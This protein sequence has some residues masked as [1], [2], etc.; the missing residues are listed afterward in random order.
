MPGVTDIPGIEVHGKGSAD[1]I[2]PVGYVD[3]S[4]KVHD[5]LVL[6]E[7]TGAEDDMMGNDDLPIGERVSNVLCACIEK[8]GDVDDKDIIKR[9]V[10]DDLEVGLPITEQDRIAAMI[11]LRRL[12]IGDLY[13]FERRCPRC[14]QMAEN[15]ATDLRT[16]KI[17]KCEHPERRRVKLVLPRSKK[18]CVIKVLTA[19]GSISVARLR[20]T[21]K[22]LKSLALIARVE[23]LDGQ[24]MGHPQ[25]ALQIIKDLPQK[26]RNYIRQVY[27]AMEAFV[28]TEIEVE[29]RNPICNAT[30]KFALDVGQGFF[31]DLEEKVSAEGLNWL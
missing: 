20:P 27:N 13:K 7:M 22:D 4:G 15:R 16:L 1:Y 31:L 10:T 25:R 24:P 23:S 21:Q 6:R 2:L 3:G 26:D 11:F 14:S 28:D 12:T 19:K 18:E 5:H 30:W 29:C 9:A 17:E 8:L